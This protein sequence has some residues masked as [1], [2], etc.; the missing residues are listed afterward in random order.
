MKVIVKRG[1]GQVT[2]S[3]VNAIA[4]EVGAPSRYFPD[5]V[6]LAMSGKTS[7]NI[8]FNWPK[9]QLNA[10]QL[11]LMR[12]GLAS[13]FTTHSAYLNEYE[14][15]DGSKWDSV[16]LRIPTYRFGADECE[17]GNLATENEDDAT[18]AS[19]EE[20]FEAPKILS[21]PSAAKI[22]LPEEEAA[23]VAKAA[24][25]RKPQKAE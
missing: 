13:R 6:S 10:S 12:V 16:N 4:K 7:G 5:L 25:K 3:V 11:E 19:Y 2:Q 21:L 23:P 8:A 9:G 22:T 1:Q 20:P 15:S 14:K 17:G 18:S 24:K